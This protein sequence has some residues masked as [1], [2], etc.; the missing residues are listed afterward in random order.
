MHEIMALD[1]NNFADLA[2]A[3]GMDLA[4]P[5]TDTKSSTLTRFSLQHKA[6]SGR[7]DIKGKMVNVEV[8]EAGS[9]KLE[10]PE[11]KELIYAQ[12]ARLRPYMQRVLY[13]RFIMGSGDT[14]NMF[15]KTVMA[16]D[17]NGD[18]KDSEGGFNCGKPAGYIKDWAAIPDPL[19]AVIKQIK[20]TRAI[21]GTVTLQGA[22]NSQGEPVTLEDNT[23]V[24]WEIDNRDAFKDSNTPFR[25][26]FA[27][28]EL[29][30]QRHINV[31]TTEKSLPNGESFYLPNLDLD[32][33]Q[34]KNEIT[35]EDQEMFSDLLSW[36]SNYNSYILR[37]WDEKT[38]VGDVPSG[39]AALID[40][41]LSVEQ[42]A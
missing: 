42:A 39:E 28:K 38:G 2:K 29:P 40:G 23:P 34:G 41:F 36:V 10:N 4:M 15:I 32:L 21:F 35:E 24:I 20:R 18:L 1:S 25:T 17:L 37:Q 30:L 3:A 33:A 26:L 13:K 7:Q 27:R 5:S 19:K 6:L 31:T 12:S 16:T 22:V 9:I 8:V 11:T 14:P